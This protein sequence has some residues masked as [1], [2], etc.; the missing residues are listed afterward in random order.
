ML[1]KVLPDAT[2]RRLQGRN[3]QLNDDVSEVA[4]DIGR[5]G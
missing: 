4:R 2:V 3:H 1:A 5:L